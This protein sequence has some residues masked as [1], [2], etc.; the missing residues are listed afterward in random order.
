MVYY[1]YGETS[2]NENYYEN[3]TWI[4]GSCDCL[5]SVEL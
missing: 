5:E 3:I 2:N 4:I 1:L